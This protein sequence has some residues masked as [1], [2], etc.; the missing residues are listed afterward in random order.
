MPSQNT[1]QYPSRYFFRALQSACLLSAPFLVQSAIAD[2][3]VNQQQV[4]EVVVT[5]AKREQLLKDFSGSI[6]VVKTDAL[7]PGASLSD[8]ANQVPGLSV[9]E[10]GPRNVTAIVMRGLRMDTVESRDFIGDGSTV[11]SYV[12]NIPL[13]GFFVP[14]SYSL[15]DL[16]QV[17]VLRGPQGTLY[18]NSSIGGLI[19]YITAK[20]DLTKNSLGVT[21]SVSHTAKSHGL[22]YD[23]DVVANLQLIEDELA[24]RV[25][26][27]KVANQGFIDN[28]YL[29]AGG[30]KDINSDLAEQV[31]ASVLWKPN[32]EF[33]LGGSY[34]YQK[35]DVDDRQATNEAFT[36]NKYE[37]SSRYEQ[38][39][40]GV[41]RLAGVDA[42]YEF[43][44]ASV[45]AS[46][47][48]YDYKVRARADQTDYLLTLDRKGG[49]GYYTAYDEFSAFTDSDI[50]VNK[51]SA[52]VRFVSPNNQSLR[53]LVGLFASNDDLDV[54]IA[55]RVPGFAAVFKESRPEDLDYLSTQDETLREQSFYAEVAYD[56]VPDWEVALGARHFR[57]D[58]KAQI[59]SLL[60]PTST[61]YSGNNYPLGCLNDDD[62]ETGALWKFSTKYKITDKQ[63]VYLS[64]A[65][66]F[67]RGG[68]NFLP[69]T[70]LAN[71]SYK[72]DTNINYEV[73]THSNFLDQKIQTNAAIF[74]IDWNDIQVKALNANGKKIVANA[75]AARSK[76]VELDVT[77][78]VL[79]ELALRLG[80]SFTD[81]E[82][83]EDITGID[84]GNG[85][86]YAGDRLP[87]SPREQWSLGF[88]YHR[89]VNTALWDADL[90]YA[91]NTGMAT[92]VNDTFID[93]AK[94]DGYGV[95][96][97][98]AGVTLRN[99]Y[100]GLYVNNL[101]DTRGITNKRLPRLYDE[102][103]QFEYI[104]RPRTV[105]FTLNYKI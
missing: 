13:Q 24:A 41:L 85:S 62:V 56:I 28:D 59:C 90:T 53:W 73:G 16:Q 97:A 98:N 92:A 32:A 40:H 83:A 55:D 82:I 84:G 75:G 77:A 6:S 36:G 71:R 94:L 102:Q 78:H 38:P 48:R 21:T 3:E 22:N 42:T 31:R 51:D 18:G 23:S 99:W 39:M 91:Y 96:N 7:N 45:T 44:W 52:E 14:P 65:E 2:V 46:V 66:G 5:A 89:A 20:P 88:N 61:V 103:G 47:N 74:Y 30:Q 80:Y 64:V 34:E 4:E 29:L 17:E 95:V 68:V 10:A 79:Q 54:V 86:A 76:G 43:D 87:G 81:A 27:S 25:L 60:F 19:R 101:T 105:G 26:L 72:A 49:W 70:T 33:S 9:I 11:T 69:V 35:N 8:V 58:D 12:D 93:Y 50:D 67:R 37:A 1:H 57:Y 104:T 100:F 63:S 15:K